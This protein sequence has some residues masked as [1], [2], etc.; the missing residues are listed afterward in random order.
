MK[1]LKNFFKKLWNV[2]RKILAVVLIIIAV[3]LAVLACFATGGASLIYAMYAIAALA[4]AFLI[5][6]DTT[7]KVTGKVGD[8]LG[9]VAETVG[10][11]GGKVAGGAATGVLGAILDNPVLLIA[12]GL[13]LWW[14]LS[15]GDDKDGREAKQEVAKPVA[16]KPKVTSQKAVRSPDSNLGSDNINKQLGIVGG[17]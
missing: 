17:V 14:A 16:S 3:V 12:G 5:D 1:W 10:S 7:S 13:L 4:G 9:S 8:A 15:D 6:K 11:I 2:I